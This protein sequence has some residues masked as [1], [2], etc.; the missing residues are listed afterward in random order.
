MDTVLG[1]GDEDSV[2]QVDIGIAEAIRCASFALR[3]YLTSSLRQM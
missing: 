1:T 3:L 2:A